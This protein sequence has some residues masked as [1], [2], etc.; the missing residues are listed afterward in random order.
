MSIPINKTSQVTPTLSDLVPIWDN[1]DSTTRNTSL[2]MLLTLIQENLTSSKAAVQY[3]APNATDFSVTVNSTDGSDR[4]LLI[5]PAA[6]YADGTIVLPSTG[7]VDK[8]TVLVTCT[9]AVTTLT[10]TSDKTVYGAPA[11]LAA[12]DFFTL[13]Y[14]LT[15][16]SWYRIG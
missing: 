15:F 4:H 14:D 1:S 3:D 10:I 13:K 8:Q 9:Q 16:D 6:G 5:V 12:D 7:L 11:A 2:S